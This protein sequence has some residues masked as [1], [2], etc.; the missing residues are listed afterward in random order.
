MK[1]NSPV[2]FFLK[3]F[4]FTG[5]LILLSLLVFN[6]IQ[7]NI[8]FTEIISGYL[9]SLILFLLGFISVNWSFKKP[10]KTFMS[11]V[12]GGILVRLVIISILIFIILRYTELSVVYFIMSF[13]FFYI[14]YQFFEFRFINANTVKGSK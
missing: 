7:G 8:Y 13:V 14:I 2:A 4:L 11:I 9:A 10:L 5:I 1:K 6:K 12:I 3:L